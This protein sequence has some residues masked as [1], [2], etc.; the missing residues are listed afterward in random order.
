MMTCVWLISFILLC[1]VTF[2]MCDGNLV[3]TLDDPYIHL[4]VAENIL[5][6]AYGV[7]Y[8]EFSTPSSSILYPF[9]LAPLLFLGFGSYSPLIVNFA[10]MAGSVW[11]ITHC[12]FKETRADERNPFYFLIA[13]L[14]IVG[15]NA[16]SL[17]LMGMEHSLH[18]LSVVVAMWGMSKF[19]TSNQLSTAFLL[20]V[21]LMPFIRFE[22]IA[23][24]LA[25][26]G[27]VFACRRLRTAILILAI[28]ILGFYLWWLFTRHMGVAF[29][30]SSVSLKSAL[31]ANAQ[32]G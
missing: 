11:L 2:Y 22:G 18:V 8:E 31:A 26:V 12:L 19:L 29:F 10:A 14:F 24:S 4:S 28:Q 9:F 16:Y 25:M 3:Y 1:V 30:P 6:G 21:T 13:F 23:L 15:L 20:A 32:G 7:N 27:V 17:P 5:K